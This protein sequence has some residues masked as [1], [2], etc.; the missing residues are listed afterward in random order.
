MSNTKTF[1][2]ALAGPDTTTEYIITIDEQ[3]RVT[4]ALAN[5]TAFLGG[6]RHTRQ[7][8]LAAKLAPDALK[9][10]TDNLRHQ[11]AALSQEGALIWLLSCEG[12]RDSDSK[13]VAITG[14]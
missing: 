4:K 1:S 3:G 12:G 13:S 9:I 10:L 7:V 6:E 11:M 5:A 8:D 14:N 2:L